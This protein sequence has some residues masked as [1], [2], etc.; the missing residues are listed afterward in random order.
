MEGMPKKKYFY[1]NARRLKAVR[2]FLRANAP[3]AEKI[4]WRHLRNNQL[5]CKFRR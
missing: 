1:Q 5:G 4:L 2:C 3:A